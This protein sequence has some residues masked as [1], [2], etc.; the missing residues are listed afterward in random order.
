MSND[1]LAHLEKE[2]HNEYIYKLDGYCEINKKIIS[3]F[4]GIENQFK[5]WKDDAS[6]LAAIE[7]FFEN[8]K[9][10]SK[11]LLAIFQQLEE[12]SDNIIYEELSNIIHKIYGEMTI[13]E[14]EL[15]N[16]K[17]VSS[18]DVNNKMVMESE[19]EEIRIKEEVEKRKLEEENRKRKEEADIRKR[20]EDKRKRE[21]TERYNSLIDKKLSLEKAKERKIEKY[22]MI[23]FFSFGIGLIFFLLWSENE[24][25]AFFVFVGFLL[26]CISIIVH[27]I[28]EWWNNR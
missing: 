17:L 12:M 9:I 13:G 25:P 19:K 27:K 22:F 26:M 8:E 16:K 20:E 4:K 28:Y 6:K 3:R 24:V 1:Y 15:Y 2:R 11:M 23:G 18:I 14:V 21:E 7:H 5:D 10:V